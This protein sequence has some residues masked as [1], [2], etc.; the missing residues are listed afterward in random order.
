MINAKAKFGYVG[1]FVYNYKHNGYDTQTENSLK[2]IDGLTIVCRTWPI[3]E[4]LKSKLLIGFRPSTT[5]DLDTIYKFIKIIFDIDYEPNNLNDIVFDY[6]RIMIIP[7][8]CSHNVMCVLYN[9]I[10]EYILQELVLNDVRCN[11]VNH[12]NA[13]EKIKRLVLMVRARSLAL[14]VEEITN[15]LANEHL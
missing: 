1:E 15:A 3:S 14:R 6:N 8:R 12:P 5:T 7:G 10:P 11:V 4:T 2:S 9:N 13:S